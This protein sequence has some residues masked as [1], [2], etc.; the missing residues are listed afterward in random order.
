MV[1]TGCVHLLCREQS[2]MM[3][4]TGMARVAYRGR[5]SREAGTL[6]IPEMEVG[7]E[8]HPLWGFDEPHAYTKGVCVLVW[9]SAS[10]VDPLWFPMTPCLLT[11]PSPLL[12]LDTR[13]RGL[14]H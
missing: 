13:H 11:L 10:P 9:P 1:E 14:A 2:M 8:K 4:G 6:S 5:L 12:R 3:L 7:E